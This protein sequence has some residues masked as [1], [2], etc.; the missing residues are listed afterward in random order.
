[1]SESMDNENIGP[2]FATF[3]FLSHFDPWQAGSHRE[4]RFSRAHLQLP[5]QNVEV[6]EEMSDDEKEA[7]RLQKILDKRLVLAAQALADDW[8]VYLFL[9][10]IQAI[11]VLAGG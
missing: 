3:N 7:I 5:T 4:L 10:G 6:E 1:M 2:L 9:I 8:P 11:P